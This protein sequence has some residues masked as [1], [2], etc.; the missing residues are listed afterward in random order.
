MLYTLSTYSNLL[1]LQKTVNNLEDIVIVCSENVKCKM[2][3]VHDI[4][5]ERNAMKY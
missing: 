1:W 4:Q 2:S 5:F 3:T